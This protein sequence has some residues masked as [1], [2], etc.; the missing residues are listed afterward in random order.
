MFDVRNPLAPIVVGSGLIITVNSGN[1]LLSGVPT[2]I[3]STVIALTQS[4][5]NF[6]HVTSGGVVAVNTSSFP[7]TSLPIAKVICSQ[8]SITS[9]VDSRPDFNLPLPIGTT[10]RSITM[11]I[12]GA[13]SVPAT[14]IHARWSCPVNCTVTGWVLLA[15]QIGSAV[16]D[17]LR[18]T[19]AGFPTTTSITGTDTPKLV[20]VRNNENLGPLSGWISTALVAGDVLEFNLVSVATCTVLTL[21]LNITV[22]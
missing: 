4:A 13:G 1:I 11:N 14:G 9:V 19:Y 6:V 17:V 12:D 10:T 7:A 15:D 22:P 21:T 18:S 3:P 8:T 2:T 20:N 5:T 16:V